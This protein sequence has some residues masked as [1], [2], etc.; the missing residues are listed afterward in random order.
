MRVQRKK[1]LKTGKNDIS[2]S[3]ALN[4]GGCMWLSDLK[5]PRS[6]HKTVR[7]GRRFHYRSLYTAM[8]KKL[9]LCNWHWWEF[10]WSVWDACF[11]GFER[12]GGSNE[13]PQSMFWAEIWKLSEIL[14][15]NFHFLVVKFSV[16]LNRLV[17][18]MTLMVTMVFK[19]IETV[20]WVS[21]SYQSFLWRKLF[22]KLYHSGII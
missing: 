21:L 7:E 14:S 1:G 13:Y 20:C 5:E 10:V 8:G 2:W 9:Y 11:G 15:E 12:R 22:P 6:E 18:V 17:F 16:Y 4:A 3:V 19:R